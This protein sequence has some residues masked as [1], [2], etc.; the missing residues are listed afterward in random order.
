MTR[1]SRLGGVPSRTNLHPEPRSGRQARPLR[2]GPRAARRRP[3]QTEVR[4]GLRPL[5]QGSQRGEHAR[6]GK[7]PPSAAAARPRPAD[8]TS[9]RVRA[10]YARRTPPAGDFRLWTRG[11]VGLCRPPWEVTMHTVDKPASRRC[12]ERADPDHRTTITRTPG[13]GVSTRS[14]RPGSNGPAA[15]TRVATDDARTHSARHLRECSADAR[16]RALAET[17]SQ[18]PCVEEAR[19]R[20][21]QCA[22]AGAPRQVIESSPFPYRRSSLPTDVTASG[23]DS[24]TP[25]RFVAATEPR[26]HWIQP[27]GPKRTSGRSGGRRGRTRVLPLE[28]QCGKEPVSS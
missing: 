12:G 25:S 14:L 5:E 8:D 6:L 22:F 28:T 18:P 1:P 19:G 24:P 17:S 11:S 26:R 10:H 15:V 16:G 2:G 23:L 7:R 9:V 20:R 21:R 4:G 13:A 27:P 3:L